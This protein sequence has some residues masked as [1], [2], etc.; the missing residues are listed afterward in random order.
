MVKLGNLNANLGGYFISPFKMTNKLGN[1]DANLLVGTLCIF[2]VS[3]F[4][5]RT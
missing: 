5:I 4:L 2:D 1:L 3:I